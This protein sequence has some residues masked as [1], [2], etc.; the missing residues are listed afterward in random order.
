VTA[1]EVGRGGAGVAVTGQRDEDQ[2][3]RR[4]R[5]GRCG[6]SEH[7]RRPTR[8]TVGNAFPKAKRSQGADVTNRSVSQQDHITEKER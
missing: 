4:R 1:V 8:K 2:E 5:M 6:T 7:L 3:S